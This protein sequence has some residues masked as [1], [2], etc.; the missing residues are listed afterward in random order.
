MTSIAL[1]EEQLARLRQHAESSGQSLD[2]VVREAVDV[3]LARL[4]EG[5][6]MDRGKRGNGLTP[7]HQTQRTMRRPFSPEAQA[8]IDDALS[9]I[10]ANVP[11]DL[12]PEEID[13]EIDAAWQEVRQERRAR[14]GRHD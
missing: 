10:R 14:R 9:R 7:Q 13:A 8:E 5:S 3:Y 11:A 6:E 12:T 4:P 2:E 1:T